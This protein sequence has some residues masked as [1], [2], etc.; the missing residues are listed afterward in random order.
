ML[1]FLHW[2]LELLVTLLVHLRY[3][4]QCWYQCT[5]VRKSTEDAL[6][7]MLDLGMAE[8]SEEMEPI[9]RDYSL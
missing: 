1:V 2:L 8:K 6:L 5:T 4:R 9:N 7:G 3:F